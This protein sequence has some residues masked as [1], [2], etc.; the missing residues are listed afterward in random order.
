MQCKELYSVDC[1]ARE[2]SNENSDYKNVATLDIRSSHSP[3]DID[4]FL[5]YSYWSG[6]FLWEWETRVYTR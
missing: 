3:I 2:W 1:I 4:I 5:T 6:I